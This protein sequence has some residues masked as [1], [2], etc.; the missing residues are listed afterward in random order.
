MK[1]R[2]TVWAV[3]VSLIAIISTASATGIRPGQYEVGLLQQICLVNDGTWYGTTFNFSGHWTNIDK[4]KDD[5]AII[6]GGYGVNGHPFGYAND[7]IGVYK[8]GDLLAARWYD[9][10]EDF[11]YNFYGEAAGFRKVSSQCDPPF[12]GNNTH[13]ASQSN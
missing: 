9:W 1:L 12:T 5:V 3:G 10:Y 8:V 2:K 13:A 7:T 11:S 4:F 6:Y